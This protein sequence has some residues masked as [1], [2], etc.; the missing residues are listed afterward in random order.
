MGK[1]FPELRKR[2]KGSVIVQ[3]CPFTKRG[4]V[5]I[6]GLKENT[7][8]LLDFAKKGKDIIIMTNGSTG[9]FYALS[10]E[11]QKQIIK[12]TVEIVNGKVPVFAGVSQ[13]SAGQ[14]IKMAKYAREA[15]A[16]CAL[17]VSPFY[18]HASR[19]GAYRFFKTVAEAVDIGIVAYNNPDVS[20]VLMPPDLMA[21][22]SKIDNIIASKDNS[23]TAASYFWKAVNID[24]KDMVLFNGLGEVEYVAAAAYGLKYRGFVNFIGNF[25]PQLPSSVYEA[26][27]SGNFK[28]AMKAL[29]KELPLLRV[30]S[31]IGSRRESI[32]VFPEWLRASTTYISVGKTAMNLMGLCGG[33]Y[34]P[35][36]LPVEDLTAGE[37]REVKRAL[38]EMGLI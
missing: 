2:L 36:Q 10:V 18:N 9:E 5:D 26:V 15:G 30:S 1:A 8:F 13:A 12:T 32:S 4:D 37:K 24:T 34:H 22:L 14:T 17:V 3:L 11:K 20:G 16:D 38:Q 27:E 25:A 35:E 6:E 29:E 33:V 7:K 28:L 21:R 23:P 19:E 31:A